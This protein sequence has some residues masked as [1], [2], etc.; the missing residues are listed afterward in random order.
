[1]YYESNRHTHDHAGTRV[2]Q[3]VAALEAHGYR[4]YAFTPG[5]LT[6]VYPD[7]VQR[8]LVRDHLAIKGAFPRLIGMTVD[9]RRRKH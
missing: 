8:E 4:N 9:E 1:M 6:R 2:E 5:R 3:V 7:D